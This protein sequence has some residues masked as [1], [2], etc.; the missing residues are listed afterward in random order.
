MP[1]RLAAAKVVQNEPNECGERG[2][3][4]DT[5]SLAGFEGSIGVPA[6]AASTAGVVGMTI[7]IAGDLASLGI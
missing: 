3:I 2:V 4:V 7:V 5:A 1:T 6:Y